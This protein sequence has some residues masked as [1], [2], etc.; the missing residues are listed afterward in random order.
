M[1]VL[2]GDPPLV[3]LLGWLKD[4]NRPN[5][6]GFMVADGLVGLLGGWWSERKLREYRRR[7]S[8]RSGSSESRS[9][10]EAALPYTAGDPPRTRNCSHEWCA[11][12]GTLSSTVYTAR[13]RPPPNW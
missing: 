11:K 12:I 5:S 8:T 10:C 9:R 1:Q 7:L 13:G 4:E 2:A 6:E 3:A